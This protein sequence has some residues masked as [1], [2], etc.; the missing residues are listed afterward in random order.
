VDF[1]GPD[2]LP[3]HAIED[4]L[5]Q[6]NGINILFTMNGKA[7]T[8]SVLSNQAGFSPIFPLAQMLPD[9]KAKIILCLPVNTQ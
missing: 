1:L 8:R 6:P 7:R 4:S 2:G 5:K 9:F 3:N